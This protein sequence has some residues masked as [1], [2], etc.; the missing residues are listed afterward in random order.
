MRSSSTV[1]FSVLAAACVFAACS[2]DA[3]ESP[4]PPPVVDA[5]KD[6]AAPPPALCP[7]G[8][9]VDWPPGPY[10]LGVSETLGKDLVFEGGVRIADFFEPC[11]PQAKVLVIRSTAG[12]CG[13]CVWHAEN[14]GAF[15]AD[16]RA[17]G[18]AVMIDLLVAD[19]DN[20]PP[21]PAALERWRARGKLTG[22]VGIDAKY[23]FA[24]SLL[25]FQPLP[26]YVL[27]DARTM[28]VLGTM[29]NPD[30]DRLLNR[31]EL[32]LAL[33]D[34]LPRPSPAAPMLFDQVFTADQMATI[35]GMKL[36]ATPP[37]DP[38]NEV[39]DAPAAAVLGKQLFFDTALS[40]S[41]TVSCG[42]CHIAE[43]TYSDGVAQSTGVAKVD[44]NS[45]SI[46]LAAHARWQFWDGRADT[47]WAQ[48][49]GPPEN[50]KEM[51]SSRL[52]VVHVVAQKYKAA[53][54]AVFTKTPLPD[55]SALPPSGK[56]GDAAWEAMA[57]ADKDA[58]TRAYVNVG[59]AI[60][61]FERSLRVKPSKLDRY[62]D[63]DLGALTAQQKSA[64]HSFLTVGCAQ[65]HW[66]PRLT[67]DAFHAIRMPT[68]RAD[69]QA[70]RGRFDVLTGLAK[71]EF[72]AA[73]KWSDAPN[74]A[75]P[76]V[77]AP[78]ATMLGAFKTPTLR[79]VAVT[80]PYG[81]G[82]TFPTLLEVVRHYGTRGNNVRDDAIGV[83]E[84]WLGNFDENVVKSMV[85]VFD[86]FDAEVLP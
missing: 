57:P 30:P 2:D 19:E 59:K 10:G 58:V 70:D 36:V 37:P 71:A 16:P 79:A 76:L 11:A 45:P 41:G 44:R 29:G 32:E 69:K 5:G 14:T 66:G 78:E 24:S 43:K 67:D 21:T 55:F 31:L 38:T 9:P 72:T 26:T 28:V 33:S 48:A 50:D 25:A 74:A 53:Y 54:D 81:H 77:F 73:S 42:T 47:T 52:F 15:L 75:K 40:P 22:K 8:V 34:R 4:P 35:R 64:L 82:G 63:G 46:A 12:F 18:R 68:G 85:N 65:C 83:A 56:P 3:S 13:P 23:T 6:G 51:A 60:A 62:I 80:A 84:P 27:V 7:G 61:A 20:M 17:K 1:A 86:A 39:A 49:L